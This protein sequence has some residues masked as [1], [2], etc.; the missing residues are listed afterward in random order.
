MYAPAASPDA[1]SA[2]T[3]IAQGVLVDMLPDV[4]WKTQKSG[5]PVHD[6]RAVPIEH[7]RNQQI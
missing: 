3:L 2:D 1:N 7:R 5:V 6:L 4:K